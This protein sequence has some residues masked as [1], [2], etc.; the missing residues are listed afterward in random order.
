NWL[1]NF[2]LSI[3]HNTIVRYLHESG[4]P[5]QWVGQG[6]R[7]ES[8]EGQPAYSVISYKWGGLDPDDG[9]PRAYVNG[10]GSKEYN[11]VYQ[12]ATFDDLIFHGSALPVYYGAFRNTWRWNKGLEISANVTYKAGYFFRRET[13]IY[14]ALLDPNGRVGHGDFSKRWQNP[15][16]EL[17][18][19]VPAMVYPVNTYRDDIYRNAEVT[20]EKGNHIRLQDVNLSY[21]VNGRN[22]GF[23][24]VKISLYARNLGIL[25]RSN[26]YKLDPDVRQ[27]PLARSYAV[28]LTANF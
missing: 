20:V 28:G 6:E 26:A 19:D 2:L 12:E 4:R 11:R 22:F 17:K 21:I 10:E 16:D 24:Q 14:G 15:G 27:L 8:R 13:I 5:S 18:T 9:S 23:T 7:V 3:N 1:T 25:W